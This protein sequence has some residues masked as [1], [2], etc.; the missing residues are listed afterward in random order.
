MSDLTVVLLAGG[1]GTRLAGLHPDL[2]KCLSSV[3]GKPFLH[4]L[5]AWFK[6]QGLD[7]FVFSLG[8]QGR[9]N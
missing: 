1:K 3:E 8:H 7:S 9:S 4:W 6:Q 5:I 2:A